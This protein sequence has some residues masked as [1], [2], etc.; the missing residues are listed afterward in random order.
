MS[1]QLES[2]PFRLAVVDTN[3]VQYRVPLWREIQKDGRI[4][5]KVFYASKVGLERHQVPGFGDSWVWDIPL[6]DG[7]T[8]EFL[9]SVGLPIF[10]KPSSDRWPLGLGKKLRE[11]EFDAV[12]VLGYVSAPAL[13]GMVA[14]WR[15]GIPVIFRGESH[16]HGALLTVRKRLKR[17]L[18]PQLMKRM[19]AFL[20]IGEWNREYWLEMGIPPKKLWD[21]PYSVD[22]DRFR[23][24]LSEEPSRTTELRRGWGVQENSVVFLYCAKLFGVKA[25][26]VLLEAFGK[27]ADAP[28]AHLVMVGT[29]PMEAELKARAE[30][31]ALQR[32]RWEGFVNQ[33]DLPFYY[34]AADVFVLPSR[35]EPWGLVVNEAMACGTPCIVSDVVGA[36]PD[37]IAGKGT[38]LIFEHDSAEDLASAMRQAM[39]PDVRQG[40]RTHLAVPLSRACFQQNV[41]TL[42]SCLATLQKRGR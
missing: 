42:A 3:P 13:A 20:A 29:G 35:F 24:R 28:N 19:D 4:A 7:Y 41:E 5:L 27:L 22:N 12:M 32:V 36:G 39:D 2:R 38:G 15:A 1:S 8:H 26:E 34:R 21:A 30:G 10:P 33:N 40:W 31:L 16:E 37:L 17:L 9:P 11:G 23:Q 25:P 18:L 14:G 6:L